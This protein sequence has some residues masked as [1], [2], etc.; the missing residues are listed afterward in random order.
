MNAGIFLSLGCTT[1]RNLYQIRGVFDSSAQYQGISL[2]NVLLPGPDSTNSLL[3]ILL[4]FRKEP[5]AMTADV[6]QMFYNFMVREDHRDFLRFLWYRDN[7]LEKDLIEYRMTVHVFGNTC[8]P[9]IATYGLRRTAQ[10]GEQE[11]GI[12]MSEYVHNNFYVD[13]GLTSLPTPEKAI[14]LMKRTQQALLSGGNI[15][16]HKIVSN[17]AKVMDAFPY[18]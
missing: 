5:I 4:R 2:N 13:D 6:E 15:R 17:S 8:S 7:D 9:A 10:I 3:G 12:D 18:G 11:F 1:R 16:L 14:D